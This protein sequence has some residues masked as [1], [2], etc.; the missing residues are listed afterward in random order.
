[1]F[2]EGGVELW[3]RRWSGS[4]LLIDL[5]LRSKVKERVEIVTQDPARVKTL[6]RV[7][8]YSDIEERDERSDSGEITVWIGDCIS[9]GIQFSYRVRYGVAILL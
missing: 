4:K 3:T 5:M 6:Q 1:M 2:W 9:K 8:I 7:E